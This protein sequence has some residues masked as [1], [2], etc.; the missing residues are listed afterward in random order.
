MKIQEALEGGI[1]FL[2][3]KITY[4]KAHTQN[5]GKAEKKGQGHTHMSVGHIPRA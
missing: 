4:I 3:S 1:L 2:G 5:Y